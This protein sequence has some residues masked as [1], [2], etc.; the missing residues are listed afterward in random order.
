MADSNFHIPQSRKQVVP[1]R[2][3]VVRH[4]RPS[5]AREQILPMRAMPPAIP[6]DFVP[7]RLLYRALGKRVLDICLVL[8][9][10]PLAL[11]LI[12][13]SAL[14][15]WI[16]GGNPFYHQDRLGRG[17]TRFRIYK[18]RTMVRNA[19]AELENCLEQCPDMRA[20]WE[21]TQK[22]KKDPRITPIGAFLRKTSLDEL[23]QLW[24]VLNGDMSVVGPRPMMP[25]QLPLYGSAH[26]YFAL[27]PGITGPWQVSERNENLF[28][29]RVDFD[30]EYNRSLSLKRDVA[31]LLQTI[32]VVLRRTGY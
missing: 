1:V 7:P 5:G 6:A 10:A 28:T 20:E 14:L 23:P 17:G 4:L 19:D 26:H 30:A 27:R 3:G 24:N 16:E 9:T 8:L 25:E 31:V 2:H 29:M 21:T 32:G 12:T 13:I 11:L 18:L 22:L 15:L